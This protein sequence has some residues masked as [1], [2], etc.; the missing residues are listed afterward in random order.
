MSVDPNALLAQFQGAPPGAAPPGGAPGAQPGGDPT[1]AVIWQAFPSTDP[2]VASQT[3]PADYIQMSEQDIQ[4]FTQLQAQAWAAAT[5]QAGPQQQT[6]QA[7]SA[8]PGVGGGLG[9]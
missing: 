6:P 1:Q 9:G 5:A 2:T 4:R 8:G 3:A 7:P